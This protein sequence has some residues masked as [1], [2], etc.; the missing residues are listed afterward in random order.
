MFT[1]YQIFEIPRT[2]RSYQFEGSNNA[3]FFQR[4]ELQRYN[5]NNATTKHTRESNELNDD[6]TIIGSIIG[7]IFCFLLF[8]LIIFCIAYPFTMYKDNPNMNSYAEDKWW[9]YHCT[10]T[11]CANKCWYNSH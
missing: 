6:G 7:C 3:S 4:P 11:W 9:C 2:E 5:N 1:K 8:L 10:D